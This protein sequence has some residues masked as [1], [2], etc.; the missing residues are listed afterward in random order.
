MT[1]YNLE[2]LT[3]SEKLELEQHLAEQIRR[4]KQ[5]SFLAFCE[6]ALEPFG[7]KP[8]AHH[9][10]LIAKLQDVADGKIK[11]LMV[12]LPPGAAKSTYGSV[13][14]PAWL[15]QRKHLNLIGAANTA[16][17]AESFS[18]RVMGT[19]RDN[20]DVLDYL[21]CRE[22]VELWDNSVGATYRAAG[23]G[24]VITG[25]RADVVLIDDPTKSRAEAESLVVRESQWNW[26]TSDLRTRLKP[27][28]SIV[29]I[30]TRWHPDD[31][32]GRLVDR[33]PGLWEVLSIPAVAEDRDPL[34]RAPGEYLWGDDKYDY[35]AE[36]RRVHS[37]YEA[38]GATR[39]WDALYQ[40]RPRSA[41]GSLFKTSQITVYDEAPAGNNDVRAWDLAA[42]S[43]VGTRDPDWTVGVKERRLN[44]G[45]Y[46]VLDVVRLRG[47][48]HEVEAAI[49]NTA[50][51]D[52][53][54]CK[55]SI[56]QDP[57]Q[58]GKAHVAHMI[59][60]LAGYTVHSSPETGDKS[61]RAA[62]FASQVNVGNVGIVKAPWNAIYLDELASF[63]GGSK[64]DQVDAS[65]RAF[66][67]IDNRAPM[68]ISL[69]ALSQF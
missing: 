63:P 68:R 67:M 18:R 69:D 58:A 43:A 34:D 10:L 1:G 17:L 66:S 49:Y 19:A 23:I 54:G 5:R 21:L 45:R 4:N 42:T 41:E 46:V 28:A 53:Y 33:Q 39:D 38:A 22:S 9:R 56:P 51:Q 29:V 26:F 15:M 40:Q 37:E 3:Y 57:G 44:D 7:Q 47:G 62:P 60:K 2:L 16:T 12:N 36:L 11:R 35:A 30:M 27:G 32:G 48:P 61:T 6:H 59:S 25:M 52:G 14:W 55:I 65:S 50:R 8:A 64:D 20:A 24:G 31:L 13:L